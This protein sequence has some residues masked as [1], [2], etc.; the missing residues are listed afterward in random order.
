MSTKK[1]TQCP[2]EK[3]L[4]D[5]HRDKRMK[6][7]HASACKVCVKKY[8][9]TNKDKI[10]SKSKEWYQK[11]I[12]QQQQRSKE[13]YHN[14]ISRGCETAR[15]SY[16]SRRSECL[17]YMKQWRRDHPD[18]VGEYNAKRRAAYIAAIPNWCEREMISELYIECRRISDSTGI[19]HHVDHIIPLQHSLVC[20]LHCF[21]N[22]QIITGK[23]N[24][25][26][27]NHYTP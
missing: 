25:S 4:E 9:T 17:E 27:N 19:I 18:Q 1:C 6:D 3:S 14:N 21:H 24:Q 23:E 15:R 5:F 10:R 16:H 2:E 26:K 20:G 8:Q 11:N 22:L 7:G 12:E 13:W